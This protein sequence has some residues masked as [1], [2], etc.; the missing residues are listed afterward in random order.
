MFT[1]EDNTALAM[2]KLGYAVYD[3][4]D[5]NR[6]L[7]FRVGFN[8]P[9]AAAEACV[10]ID[11]YNEFDGRRVAKVIT[12]IAVLDKY[13]RVSVG[14]EGSPVV[15][16]SSWSGDLDIIQGMLKSARPDECDLESGNTVRAWWD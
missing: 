7:N 13:A 11:S 2:L 5:Q 4:T 9:R 3:D 1:S 16:V 12:D 10:I 6:C 8:D 14:R 15:Y